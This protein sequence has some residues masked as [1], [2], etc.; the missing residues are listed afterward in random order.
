MSV[1]V[2]VSVCVCLCVHVILGTG[3]CSVEVRGQLCILAF[4]LTLRHLPLFIWDRVL[5]SLEVYHVGSEP[6]GSS[7]LLLS[8]SIAH[9]SHKQAS[10][11]SAFH[12]GWRGLSSGLHALPDEPS[13][14]SQT[15]VFDSRLY[16]FSFFSWILSF[17]VVIAYFFRQK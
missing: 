15:C 4:G 10:L 6:Q 2:C 5:V 7:R 11:C 16:G 9:R 3:V 14:G 8:S 12:T 17:G 1:C 13:P